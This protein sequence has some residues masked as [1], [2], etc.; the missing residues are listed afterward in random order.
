M[1][2]QQEKIWF[3]TPLKY[4]GTGQG[5]LVG[6]PLCGGRDGGHRPL[7]V[8]GLHC[9]EQGPGPSFYNTWPETTFFTSFRITQSQKKTDALKSTMQFMQQSNLLCTGGWPSPRQALIHC[10]NW[11]W[12]GVS[13]KMARS[14]TLGVT[15][16][17]SQCKSRIFLSCPPF[18]LCGLDMQC[19]LKEI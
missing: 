13:S 10:R 2:K 16:F 18:R 5:P 14:A 11:R 15:K 1:E 3:T 19:I 6:V 9:R 4:R 8:P 7:P 12:G 17:L